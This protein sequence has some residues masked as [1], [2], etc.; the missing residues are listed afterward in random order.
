MEK[1]KKDLITQIKALIATNEEKVPFNEK[2]IEYFEIDELIE[3]KDILE[4]K[5]EQNKN[6]S[7]DYL[8]DIFNKCS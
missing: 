3:I 5:K 4:H 7:K 6:P 2:Y 8:D 1:E